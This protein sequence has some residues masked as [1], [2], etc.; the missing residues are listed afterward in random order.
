[1]KFYQ[2]L[3]FLHYLKLQKIKTKWWRREEGWRALVSV[4][5]VSLSSIQTLNYCATL[6]MITNLLELGSYFSTKLELSIF[7]L[8]SPVLL[9]K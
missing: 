2:P 8:L 9:S 7:T 1:V 3:S 6:G 4:T 5:P